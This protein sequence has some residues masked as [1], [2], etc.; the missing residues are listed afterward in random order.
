[1]KG[2]LSD[3]RLSHFVIVILLLGTGSLSILGQSSNTSF[4]EAFSDYE[5]GLVKLSQTG[6]DFERASA[7]KSLAMVDSTEYAGVRDSLALSKSTDVAIALLD[8]IGMMRDRSPQAIDY[9]EKSLKSDNEQILI[10]AISI[11]N[12]ELRVPLPFEKIWE[13]DKATVFWSGD[14]NLPYSSLDGIG[15]EK[16]WLDPAWKVLNDRKK[17]ALLFRA[18]T[19]ESI[20]LGIKVG[21][22]GKPPRL[23]VVSKAEPVDINYLSSLLEDPHPRIRRLALRSLVAAKVPGVIENLEELIRRYWNG[24]DNIS[25]KDIDDAGVGQVLPDLDIAY[26]YGLLINNPKEWFWPVYCELNRR[27]KPISYADLRGR[28]KNGSRFNLSVVRQ[29]LLRR[30]QL[31]ALVRER[32]YKDLP[33]Y[34]T[35]A[36]MNPNPAGSLSDF[37]GTLT[38]DEDFRESMPSD[39]ASKCKAK[40]ENWLKLSPQE[41]GPQ[42]ANPNGSGSAKKLILYFS[43]QQDRN[44]A[45]QKFRSS[46]NPFDD[47]GAL[48]TVIEGYDQRASELRQY[49]VRFAN[50]L[51]FRKTVGYEVMGTLSKA[52]FMKNLPDFCGRRTMVPIN[53][54][55]MP[56]TVG[57]LEAKLN[58][59]IADCC[60]L[61]AKDFAKDFLEMRGFS[62]DEKDQLKMLHILANPSKAVRTQARLMIAGDS[63]YRKLTPSGPDPGEEESWIEANLRRLS[64]SK[65]EHAASPPGLT[66]KDTMWLEEAIKESKKNYFKK[67]VNELT[68]PDKRKS[69]VTI[70]FAGNREY[71]PPRLSIS[72]PSDIFI[73]KAGPEFRKEIAACLSSRDIRVRNAAAMALWKMFRDPYALNVFKKEAKTGTAGQ[74]A[75][76]LNML[77]LSHK[78]EYA[79]LFP[80]LLTNQDFIL[81]EVGL[82]G[83]CDFKLESNLPLVIS[84]VSDQESGPFAIETLGAW[85][86]AEARP[87][88]L[89]IVKRDGPFSAAAASALVHYRTR[90]D[91]DKLL[92][93]VE[94]PKCPENAKIKILNTMSKITLRIKPELTHD[95]STPRGQK[96]LKPGTINEWK[97]WWKKHRDESP[98]KRARCVIGNQVSLLVSNPK[99]ATVNRTAWKLKQSFSVIVG[100]GAWSVTNDYYRNKL[101]E[102]WNVYQRKSPWELFTC[103]EADPWT[104]IDLLWEIDPHATRLLLF[105]TFYRF[106]EGDFHNQWQHSGY[107]GE[108]F[109]DRLVR[110]AGIDFGDPGPA[111]C[112]ERNKILNE[113]LTW[114]QK[115]GWAK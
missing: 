96:R 86:P 81:R 113:W 65:D 92:A 5:S 56:P 82:F 80:P 17:M 60:D 101:Q 40:I 22:S 49:L 108:S 107:H 16:P 50:N 25:D 52:G 91:I 79:D 33:D 115:E 11:Y 110:Y 85:H 88:L 67:L 51:W 87:L 4:A 114:A 10:E 99:G 41:G 112:G 70:C 27:G 3:W 97:T 95:P 103:D 63:S 2:L 44:A 62:P 54:P 47:R 78:K 42:R 72:K 59:E 13:K 105:M 58:R 68:D 57:A 1:M 37:A 43:D 53:L 66:K 77:R 29:D 7:I 21:L 23:W 6:T 64:A 84:L 38:R 14:F 69:G 48:E 111:R 46:S 94:D 90:E 83:V 35:L 36:L 75:E 55:A 61:T 71:T 93:T 15:Q 26:L 20:P 76:A 18:G 32:I 34:L 19:R 24:V 89:T 104:N 74:K 28:G 31:E 8:A 109:H 9:I 98:G 30:C 100:S 73:R 12:N 102:W 45:W 106:S 39:I